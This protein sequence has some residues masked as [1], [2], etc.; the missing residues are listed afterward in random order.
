MVLAHLSGDLLDNGVDRES[1][2]TTTIRINIVIEGYFFAM[3][4]FRNRDCIYGDRKTRFKHCLQDIFYSFQEF[5]VFHLATS[6]ASF[7]NL[8]TRNQNATKK[9]FSK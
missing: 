5:H 3:R 7:Q 2:Y 1:R 4:M 8:I 9:Y 6:M